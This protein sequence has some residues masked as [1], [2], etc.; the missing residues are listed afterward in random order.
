MIRRKFFIGFRLR[1]FGLVY[2]FFF[3]FLVQF[4]IYINFGM[5]QEKKNKNQNTK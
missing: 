2:N 4:I 3:F 1:L 5:K